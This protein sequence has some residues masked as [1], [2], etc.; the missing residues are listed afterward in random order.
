[1]LNPTGTSNR[2]GSVLDAYMPLPAI[3]SSVDTYP[4]WKTMKAYLYRLPAG[5]VALPAINDLRLSVQFS[6]RSVSAERHLGS[7]ISVVQLNLDSL[8]F[9]PAGHPVYWKW[10]GFMELL[11]IQISRACLLEL[12]TQHG[13]DG[14][15][16]LALDN[17][18]VRDP[19][20]TQ[21]AHELS[22]LISMKE[23]QASPVYLDSLT[24]FLILHIARK[25]CLNTENQLQIEYQE[26]PRAFDFSRVI[27]Y[28]RDN[29][30]KDLRLEQ[31]ARIAKL[32]NF[33]FIKQFRATFGTSP[34]Q[35]ILGC[36][37]ALAKQLLTETFLSMS[38]ISQRCGFSSQ[39]HFT[40]V[41]RQATGI[42]PRL[43]RFNNR[44]NKLKC[45]L[46]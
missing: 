39:S 17:M 25:Y 18:G 3:C 45:D 42:P 35:Y 5:Q 43:F 41:F 27:N 33:Y 22:N 31:L 10:D 14:E 19:M 16:L 6:A 12:A 44:Q 40:S 28:I 4:T 36:R 1:M 21:I 15:K 9:C 2:S 11:Q 46:N 29:L 30:E 26:K 38:H 7:N 34:H 37:I 20:I 8:T 13:L 32:S 24:S 23:K